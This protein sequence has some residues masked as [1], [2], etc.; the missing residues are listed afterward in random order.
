MAVPPPKNPTNSELRCLSPGQ[1]SA[2]A[3]R[4][5]QCQ[6]LQSDLALTQKAY[7]D[8][9]KAPSAADHWWADPKIVIGGFVITATASALLTY[10]IVNETNR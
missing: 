10:V 5:V 1:V 8:A 6:K 7:E 9:V 4:E 3:N 2:L